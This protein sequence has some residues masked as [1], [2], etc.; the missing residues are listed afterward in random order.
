MFKWLEHEPTGTTYAPR[1]PDGD[2]WILEPDHEPAPQLQ[3]PDLGFLDD[4]THPLRGS[5]L[6]RFRT[7]TSVAEAASR[8]EMPVTRLY[9]HVNKLLDRGLIR[10]VAHRQVGAR[11]E[12][13]YQVV[14][15]AFQIDPAYLESSE[16]AEVATAI[17]SVF[18]FAKADLARQI[19][20]EVWRPESPDDAVISLGQMTLSPARRTELFAALNATLADFSSDADEV[21]DDGVLVTMLIAAFP[22]S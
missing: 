10:P 8:L 22:S 6:R 13:R 2:D 7:P 11:T 18:D 17:G 21:D 4:V 12:T 15:H 20:D 5:L 3:F 1:M 14:A 16:P 9:H 19:E